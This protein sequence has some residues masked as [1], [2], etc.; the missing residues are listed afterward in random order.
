MKRQWA[1]YLIDQSFVVRWWS[2]TLNERCTYLFCSAIFSNP[3]PIIDWTEEKRVM[4]VADKRGRNRDSHF[5]MHCNRV[6]CLVN[7][8]L[9]IS[10][11]EI[12]SE[13]TQGVAENICAQ[14]YPLFDR[15]SFFLRESLPVSWCTITSPSWRRWKSHHVVVVPYYRRRWCRR[16]VLP[17]IRVMDI[18]S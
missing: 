4:S 8:D 11:A 6:Y 10:H 7:I 12:E 16:P 5:E 9:G 14:T 17:L 3:L 1:L 18:K 2:E 15:S 13:W